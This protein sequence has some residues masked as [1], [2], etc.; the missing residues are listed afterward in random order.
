MTLIPNTRS[1]MNQRIQEIDWKKTPFGAET[2]WPQELR[3]VLSLCLNTALP[4]ALYWGDDLRLLYNDAWAPIAG[5]KH[6]W[7]LGRPARE[8]WA[9][10]WHVIEPQLLAVLQT[11]RGFSVADQMLPMLRGGRI[12]QTHWDYSFA[13]IFGQNGK[14]LGIFNQGNETT[15]RLSAER[16]LRASEERL[17][18]ALGALPN[19]MAFRAK[20]PASAHRSP[21]SSTPFILTTFPMWKRRSRRL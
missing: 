13:P 6:P 18:Y 2:D 4:T 7:A 12:Q 3:M 11:G 21:I 19:S 8:V 14:V 16:A 9:D 5:E 20:R 17:E 10:I 15:A 1:E